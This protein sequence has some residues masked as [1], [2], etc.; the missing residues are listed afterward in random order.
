[1][2]EISGLKERGRKFP[3]LIE[4]SRMLQRREKK[5][6]IDDAFSTGSGLEHAGFSRSIR[7][8]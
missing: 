2:E 5:S 7:Y 8:L 3:P 4:W 1:M 6:E